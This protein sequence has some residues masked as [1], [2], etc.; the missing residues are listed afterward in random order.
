MNSR[1]AESCGDAGPGVDEPDRV[2]VAFLPGDV[3]Q[4]GLVQPLDLL[5][6]RQIVFGTFSPPQGTSEDFIDTDRNGELEP[7]D[8]LRFRQLVQGT[9]SATQAWAGAM[10]DA[11]RP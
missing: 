1:N 5:R 8:L 9:G 4:S 2:D 10:L 6:F 11:P 3:D 7:L